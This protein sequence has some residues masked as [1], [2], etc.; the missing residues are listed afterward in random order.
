MY[1]NKI[2]IYHLGGKNIEK[3]VRFILAILIK[4]NMLLCTKIYH[5]QE[6]KSRISLFCIINKKRYYQAYTI[7]EL[8]LILCFF[9]VG[10]DTFLVGYWMPDIWY[11]A[12]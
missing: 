6:T 3:H 4:K 10:L 2:I 11:T 5:L 8:A 12:G 7:G 1:L 9:M